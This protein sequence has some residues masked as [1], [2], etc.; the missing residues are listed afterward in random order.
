M[1]PRW[2][3]VVVKV[4]FPGKEVFGLLKVDFLGHGDLRV[5]VRG[6]GAGCGLLGKER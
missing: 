5:I 4:V 6:R 1:R 2:L 3:R